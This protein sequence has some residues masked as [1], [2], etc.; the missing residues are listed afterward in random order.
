MTTYW[1]AFEPESSLRTKV[2]VVA[3]AVAV[4]WVVDV[5]DTVTVVTGVG[6]VTTPPVTPTQLQALESD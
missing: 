4:E 6:S 1:P 3:V 2:E 5:E